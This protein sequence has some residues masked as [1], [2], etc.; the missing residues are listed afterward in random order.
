MPRLR[1]TPTFLALPLVLG[2]GAARDLRQQEIWPG[3]DLP[4]PPADPLD[5]QYPAALTEALSDWSLEAT[6]MPWAWVLAGALGVALVYGLSI[7]AHELGHFFAARR[8]GA[9]VDA[10]TLHAAGGFVDIGDE[11]SLTRGRF[12]LIVAA[13]PL[14]T[15]VLAAGAFVL[16]G[17]EFAASPAGVVAE[18]LITSAVWVNAVA[19]A[20]NLLPLRGL[21]GWYLLKAR[22]STTAR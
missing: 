5:P 21:D 22:P 9:D 3:S 10:V 18:R 15:A 20:V 12:A 16:S 19:L 17:V 4:E 7:L 1:V 8:L 2:I 11:A 13:G 14:V 6:P